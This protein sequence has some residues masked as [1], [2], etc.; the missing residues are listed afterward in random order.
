M[1]YLL[2]AGADLTRKNSAGQ[3]A[4]FCAAQFPVGLDCAKILYERGAAL[5]ER[6]NTNMTPLIAAA[7]EGNEEIVRFLLFAGADRH[8]LD[9]YDETA[10]D[11]AES[12]GHRMLAVL[13]RNESWPAEDENHFRKWNDHNF[14]T[15]VQSRAVQRLLDAQDTMEVGSGFGGKAFLCN[16]HGAKVVVKCL[17]E[18]QSEW[19]TTFS[20]KM[21]LDEAGILY[22]LR[23]PHVVQLLSVSKV[24]LAI[25]LEFAELGSLESLVR[26][27]SFGEIPLQI[28]LWFGMQIASGLEYLHSE[29]VIHRDL[30]AGNVLVFSGFILKLSDFG[31]SRAQ[32]KDG[33]LETNGAGMASHVAPECFDRKV[34]FASDMYSL[35]ITLWEIVTCGTPPWSTLPP[36]LI[37]EKVLLGERPALAK[38]A[39]PLRSLIE[40]CWVQDRKHRPKA[41]VVRRRLE[42]LCAKNPHTRNQIRDLEDRLAAL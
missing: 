25:V 16:D 23:H 18:G 29:R 10:A 24:P 30:K 34:S 35:A 14:M 37:M 42:G 27:F 41:E 40:E 20:T 17:S 33:T 9:D 31:L 6:D 22:H 4:F 12:G 26:K 3:S 38:V 11:A 13:L 8:L 36:A 19:K 5:D 28:M 21:L 39:E 2:D 7:H 32:N 15:L 1:V